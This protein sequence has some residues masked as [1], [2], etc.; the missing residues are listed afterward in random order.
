ML[1]AGNGSGREISEARLDRRNRA[2]CTLVKV[3]L[4]PKVKVLRR[5]VTTLVFSPVR[6]ISTQLLPKSDSVWFRSFEV[7]F[8]CRGRIC[9]DNCCTVHVYW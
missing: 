7:E 3:K 2:E 9:V 4:L 5:A 1:T 8:V 6:P